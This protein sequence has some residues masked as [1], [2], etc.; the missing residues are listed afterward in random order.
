MAN[1]NRCPQRLWEYTTWNAQKHSAHPQVHAWVCLIQCLGCADGFITWPLG[2]LGSCN[3]LSKYPWTSHWVL[4]QAFA[5]AHCNALSLPPLPQAAVINS[6]IGGSLARPINGIAAGAWDRFL[7]YEAR[8]Q[9]QSLVSKPHPMNTQIHFT[10]T[11]CL[12]LPH[13]PPHPRIVAAGGFLKAKRPEHSFPFSFFLL[14]LSGHIRADSPGT[15]GGK[16]ENRGSPLFH[17]SRRCGTE[18]LAGWASARSQIWWCDHAVLRHRGFYCC[19]CPVYTYAGHL[20][21]ERA[22]HTLWLPVWHS[23]CL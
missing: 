8:P 18:T 7:H 12:N 14:P 1:D 5:S 20:H 21:A 10:C 22:L 4:T 15:G 3:L 13:Y 2:L 6:Y 17:I 11:G 16:E 23:G 19:V 9:T